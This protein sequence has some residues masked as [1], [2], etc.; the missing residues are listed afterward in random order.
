[1]LALG[2]AITLLYRPCPEISFGLLV[3]LL[4]LAPTSSFVPVKDAMA[5]RRM[6]LPVIG[7]II[8]ALGIV[9]RL[10]PHAAI[11]RSLAAAVLIVLSVA[12]FNR[13]QAWASDISIWQDAAEKNPRNPRAHTSLGAALLLAGDC[14]RA[15]GQFSQAVALEGLTE[16][17][18]RNLGA[19]YECN[20]QPDLA[21]ATYQRLVLVHPLAEAY[22]RIGYL[23]ALREN[24]SAAM[25]AFDTSLRLDPYN[26]PAYAYRGVARIAGDDL[27]GAREDFGRALS[28]DPVNAVATSWMAKLSHER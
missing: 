24:V 12:S 13:S 8:A 10:Q 22:A 21:L 4:A 1:M 5:E 28:I 17:N 19:A 27:P 23:E 26:A 11:I 9:N 20:H 15:A 18:G 25:A 16:V 2:L 3:F 7:L 6:Y 14:G